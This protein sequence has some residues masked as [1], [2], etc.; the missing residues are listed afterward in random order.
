MPKPF[1]TSIKNY[2]NCINFVI[3]KIFNSLKMTFKFTVCSRRERNRREG[4]ADG[5]SPTLQLKQK[6]RNVKWIAAEELGFKAEPLA[7]E[8]I[9]PS[10][11]GIVTGRHPSWKYT[12]FPGHQKARGWGPVLWNANSFCQKPVLFLN[13]VW[14]AKVPK[15]KMKWLGLFCQHLRTC[16]G[17][18]HRWNVLEGKRL[19][20]QPTLIHVHL[21]HPDVWGGRYASN[22]N[23]GIMH[24]L[25]LW[26]SI[27]MQSHGK[28]PGTD[29]LCP[30]P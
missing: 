24:W 17:C 7:T 15:N 13:S 2:D 20:R 6:D 16:W 10:L 3:C 26:F 5:L 18:L 30:K 29:I 8:S 19:P 12:A 14:I 23:C 27:W 21:Q 28:P 4:K 11:H 9:T 1:H 22:L 25:S